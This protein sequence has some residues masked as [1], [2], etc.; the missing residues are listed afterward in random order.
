MVRLKTLDL[1]LILEEKFSAI[2]HKVC[3]LL[4][5][6]IW[7]SSLWAIF[8]LH[9]IYWGLLLWKGFLNGSVGKE[10]T[11]N[12]EETEDMVSGELDSLKT[13]LVHEWL[14]SLMLSVRKKKKKLKTPICH[15]FPYFTFSCIFI[16]SAIPENYIFLSSP[17]AAPMTLNISS[18]LLITIHLRAV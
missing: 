5:C 16:F 4:A 10:S 8:F 9:L 12:A 7:A 15:L 1:F 13:T 2:H 11:C 17:H 6:Y 14:S 18:L 3:Q